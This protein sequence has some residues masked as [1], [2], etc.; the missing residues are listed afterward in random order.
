MTSITFTEMCYS[1]IGT[2]L[3][4]KINCAWISAQF[5]GPGFVHVCTP[6]RHDSLLSYQQG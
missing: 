4:Y 2:G 5:Q 3:V 1:G 6:S